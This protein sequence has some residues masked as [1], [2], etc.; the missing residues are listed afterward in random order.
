MYK[1]CI[2]GTL[3]AG[4]RRRTGQG[5]AFAPATLSTYSTHA[6]DTYGDT[7]RDTYGEETRFKKSQAPRCEFGDGVMG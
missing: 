3:E 5:A 1:V 6:R 2:K 7:Y 4:D